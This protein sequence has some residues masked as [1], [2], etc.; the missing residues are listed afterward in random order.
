MEITTQIFQN[1][2][3]Q[4]NKLYMKVY[5][6]EHKEPQN[7]ILYL[8]LKSEKMPRQLGNLI[9]LTR[10]FFCKRNSAKHFHHK[11]KGYGFNWSILQDPYL[12]IEKIH[13]VVDESEQYFFNT[14]VIKEYGTFLNFKDQGFE[15]QRFLPLEIIKSYQKT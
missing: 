1:E 4:G 15:L 10:T 5:Y 11:A 14:S 12:S 8:K 9:F 2:D 7:A 13:L 3:K 6:D